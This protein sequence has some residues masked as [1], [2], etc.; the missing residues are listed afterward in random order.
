MYDQCT[1]TLLS[2]IKSQ[3]DFAEKHKIKDVVWLMEMMKKLSIGSDDNGNDIL[4]A[5]DSQG[6]LQYGSR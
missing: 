1:P 3:H 4:R 6:V 5:H 2:D